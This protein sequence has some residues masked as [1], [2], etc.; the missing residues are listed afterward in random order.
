MLKNAAPI[1]LVTALVGALGIVYAQ[2]DQAT[3]LQGYA[4]DPTAQTCVPASPQ[5]WVDAA[6][7]GTHQL[8]PTVATIPPGDYTLTQTLVI[9][10]PTVLRADGV[11]LRGPEGMPAITLDNA[12]DYSRVEGLTVVGPRIADGQGSTGILVRAHS[13]TL[14][15][16]TVDRVTTGVHVDGSDASPGN[17]NANGFRAFGLRVWNAR[18]GMRFEGADANAGVIVGADFNACW[19]GI[20][21]SSFLGNTF[22]GT[23]IHPQPQN[24]TP[25]AILVDSE[26]SSSVWIG[27]YLEGDAGFVAESRKT[28]IV[29]GNAVRAASV[30]NGRPEVIGERRGRLWFGESPTEVGVGTDPMIPFRWSY[31]DQHQRTINWMIRRWDDGRWCI[32]TGTRAGCAV[33]WQDPP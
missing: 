8:T 11:V 9:T 4:W 29:G 15:D 17:P 2:G 33:T 21:E 24:A 10:R 32:T 7:Q 27:T 13:A 6:A 26:S 1:A 19:R 3:C 25:P 18:V 22:V 28:L 31:V 12:A 16:V 20:E 14:R 23:T 5:A 30:G